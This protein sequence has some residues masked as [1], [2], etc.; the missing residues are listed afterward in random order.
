MPTARPG[1]S[2]RATP[3]PISNPEV[4]PV[5][6]GPAVASERRRSRPVL[7]PG[8]HNPFTSPTGTLRALDLEPKRI[9]DGVM[10]GLKPNEISEE[11]S[12]NVSDVRKAIRVLKL[13]G[14]PI[15]RY[16]GSYIIKEI[17][18][19]EPVI[20][21]TNDLLL[22]L[23]DVTK[24]IRFFYGEDVRYLWPYSVLKGSTE[25][26]RIQPSSFQVMLEEPFPSLL[27]L[28]ARDAIRRRRHI[29]EAVRLLNQLLYK[30]RVRLELSDGRTLTGN[31]VNVTL[32]GTAKIKV[33]DRILEVKKEDVKEYSPLH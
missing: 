18:V 5:A 30:G 12:V 29:P 7:G 33:R 14:L 4:K 13:L 21:S 28:R 23:K 24:T 32:K 2:D 3:G 27:K 17:K 9:L 22:V 31:L 25:V 1:H 16:K 8:L 20:G 19:E 6:R 26:A 11:L 15:H 10:R